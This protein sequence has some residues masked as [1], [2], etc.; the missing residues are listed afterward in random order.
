MNEL[1]LFGSTYVVVL[2]LGLQ[3][4]NVG[5]GHYVAAFV[6]A[7]VISAANLALFK[8]APNAT[9]SEMAA[10]LLGGPFGIVTAMYVHPRIA[11]RRP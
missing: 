3:Q 5:G 10:F 4:F 8:L 2:A 11:R 6:T 7:I 9:W 1:Y